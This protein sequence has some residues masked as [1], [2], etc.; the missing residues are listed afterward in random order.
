MKTTVRD[1]S[2]LRNPLK[3]LIHDEAP[4]KMHLTDVDAALYRLSSRILRIVECKH[5]GEEL[6]RSQRDIL[7][8]LALLIEKGIQLGTV[9]RGSGVFVARYDE[10][11]PTVRLGR[12]K[13][14]QPFEIEEWEEM[15]IDRFLNHWVICYE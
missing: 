7:P 2:Y 11:D 8:L 15:P 13:P 4:H 14:S 5:R 10:G 3:R 9:S 1:R 12:V 6:R